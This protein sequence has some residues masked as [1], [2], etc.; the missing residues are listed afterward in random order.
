[1][2]IL[3][4]HADFIEYETKKKAIKTPEPLEKKGPVRVEEALVVF[5]SVEKSDEKVKKKIIENAVKEILDVHDQVK[6]KNIVIYPFVHLSHT[7]SSPGT[8]LEV[9]KGIEKKL[10][11]K[12][13]KVKRSPFGWYKAFDIRCKG[14]PLAELSR[15]ITSEGAKEGD[16]DDVSDAIKKEGE[17][18]SEWFIVDTAGKFHKISIK[19][20]KISGF[21]FRN[22]P[23]L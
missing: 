17:L 10:L 6:A 11:E 1:M 21:D 13:L 5:S 9:V 14:H 12:K 16:E 18:K 4:I 20:D 22:N 7:P 15:D 2:K 8:A 23:K 19:D 3:L